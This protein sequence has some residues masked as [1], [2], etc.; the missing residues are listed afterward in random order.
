MITNS[1]CLYVDIFLLIVC[2]LQITANFVVLLAWC[3][4]KRLIRNDNLI[5]LISL[6]FID[7]VYAVLQF[8][9]LI[10]LIAGTK[11]DDIPLDYDP[12]VIVPLAGPSAA[13][14]KSGCTI[15]TAIAV[16]RI[17]AL[18]FPMQYYKRSKRIWTIGAFVFAILLAFI[19]WVVLQ[20]TVT[21]R[22]LP[23]CNSF[24]CFTNEVFRAYWGL[25][26]LMMNLLSCLLTLVILYYLWKGLNRSFLST[27]IERQNSHR[28]DKSANRVSIYI[29]LVSAL[30]GVV[31]GGLNGLGTI[32]HLPILDEISFFVGTCATL[33]GLSH[34]FIFAMAHRDIKQ[35]ILTKFFQKKSKRRTRIEP[36]RT[37]VTAT[38]TGVTT[39]TSNTRRAP[40]ASVWTVSL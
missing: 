27:Q 7:F 29:L 19:D 34:A 31:P 16:D 30:M 36:T 12:W 21:I 25:S 5:L 38:R 8:P 28:I 40:T 10:I 23:Y 18:C 24:G 11:P 4:S 22:R 39:V 3:T 20:L 6:A 33:S 15:T 13:L 17:I 14:M 37:G 35:A 32:V 9:Y 2:I 1:I 26:N